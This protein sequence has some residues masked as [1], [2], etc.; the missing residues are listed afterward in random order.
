MRAV[1]P[2]IRTVLSYRSASRP[3]HRWRT[4]VERDETEITSPVSAVE[5]PYAS[6]AISGTKTMKV[7]FANAVISW[8]S[9]AARTAG[10]P[11]TRLPDRGGLGRGP[12]SGTKAMRTA[13]GRSENAVIARKTAA[14]PAVALI[15]PP[16]RG[17]IPMPG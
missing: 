17:P 10:A 4:E 11:K 15:T 1:P 16:A 8:K 3:D 9:T 6:E 2:T 14:T 13:T 12:G 5:R 7:P